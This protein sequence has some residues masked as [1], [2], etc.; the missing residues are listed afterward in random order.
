MGRAT[1]VVLLLA[2]ALIFGKSLSFAPAPSSALRVRASSA[3][4][5]LSAVPKKIAKV[6]E[7]EHRGLCLAWPAGLF[8]SQTPAYAGGDLL[9][10]AAVYSQTNPWTAAVIFT[11]SFGI[12]SLIGQIALVSSQTNSQLT[13]LESKIDESQ[14][15]IVESLTKILERLERIEAQ[16]KP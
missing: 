4:K 10:A 13:R 5:D 2:V 15:K 7:F 1:T 8:L 9:D 12:A 3:I 16:G 14:T 11:L 6:P